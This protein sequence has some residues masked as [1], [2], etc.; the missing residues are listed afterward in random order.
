MNAKSVAVNLVK[1][2]IIPQGFKESSDPQIEDGE[3]TIT[4]N[5]YVQVGVFEPY[6]MLHRWEDD[7]TLEHL[8]EFVTISSLANKIKKVTT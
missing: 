7:E 3:V 6:L 4:E 1:Y 2:G 8:G 5:L